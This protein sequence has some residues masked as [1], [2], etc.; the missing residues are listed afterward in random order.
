MYVKSAILYLVYFYT[1]LRGRRVIVTYL[2]VITSS[3]PKPD[4]SQDYLIRERCSAQDLN[5]P[6]RR[7]PAPGMKKLETLDHLLRTRYVPVDRHQ[8]RKCRWHVSRII[9]RNA[10]V[11]FFCLNTFALSITSFNDSI[12][13][14]TN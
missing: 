7:C 11:I 12:V 8:L 3:V 6:R 14:E 10:E 9:K 2:I 13:S 4:A 5:A 1:N